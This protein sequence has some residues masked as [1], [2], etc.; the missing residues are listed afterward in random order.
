MDTIWAPII[1]VIA[2]AIS[3]AAL[4]LVRAAAAA[5]LNASDNAE[6]RLFWCGA[7]TQIGAFVGSCATFVT[8]NV[9]NL[10]ENANPCA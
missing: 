8:V 6:G 5:R 1:A 9:L 2:A 7:A 10:F 3:G 4:P